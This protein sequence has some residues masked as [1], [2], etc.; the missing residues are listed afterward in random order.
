MFGALLVSRAISVAVNFSYYQIH[1]T[2][3]YQVW[4]GGLSGTGA[5]TGGIFT[6][7]IIARLWNIHIGLL[8]DT[9]LP[10]AG[11]LTLAAWLGC[12]INRCAYGLPSNAWWAIP[13]RDEWGL[14]EN[15]VPVQLVGAVLTLIIFWLLDSA[16]KHFHLPGLRAS[17][18]FLSIACVMFALSYLRADPTPIWRGLRL[19]AWGALAL[20]IFAACVVV[21]LL[22]R[23]NLGKVNSPEGRTS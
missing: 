4:L 16:G 11:T 12:W 15:R 13:A 21:V 10:L 14:L 19:D 9:L 6:I 23:W 8:A 17:L 18:G 1:P 3:I 22:I 7:I 20:M 2:E 5:L